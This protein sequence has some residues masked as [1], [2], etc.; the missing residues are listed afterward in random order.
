MGADISR[1]LYPL[2]TSGGFYA[3]NGFIKR[4]KTSGSNIKIPLKRQ[5]LT[6]NIIAFYI[7]VIADFRRVLIIARTVKNVP[8]DNPYF[9]LDNVIVKAFTAFY[10][11]HVLIHNF[12][13]DSK[14]S[15]EILRFSR[16]L[17]K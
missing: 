3:F 9:V 16:E 6:P 17:K 13:F 5:I 7:L 12:T 10:Y 15:L 2:N 1:L 4:K 8:F 11:L 14:S